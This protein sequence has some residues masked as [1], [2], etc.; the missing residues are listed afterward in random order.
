MADKKDTKKEHDEDF[1]YIVRLADTDIDGERPVVYGL[2]A[3]KGIGIRMATIVVKKSG[4]QP[5]VKIGTLSDE[6]V[7]RLK[8]ALGVLESEAPSWI[9]N[10]E[11]DYE[12]GEDRHMIGVEVDLQRKD[13]LNLL[14]KIRCYKGVRHETGHKVRGQKTRSNGRKGL[15]LGV[16]KKRS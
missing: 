7:Q 3:I 2:T 8:D 14:K 10:R 13:D 6:D 11:K 5:T 4:V 12:T 16:S 1:K 9:L 15:T